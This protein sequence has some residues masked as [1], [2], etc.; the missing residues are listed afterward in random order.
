MPEISPSDLALLGTVANALK[1]GLPPH[2]DADDLIQAGYF[3]LADAKRRFDPQRGIKFQTYATPRIRGAMLDAIREADWAPRLVR[4]RREKVPKIH[5]I[6]RSMRLNGLGAEGLNGREKLYDFPD[7]RPPEEPSVEDRDQFE[8]SL[9]FLHGQMRQ[10]ILLNFREDKNL[11][12]IGDI[13]GLSESR[14]SQIRGQAFRILRANMNAP[15]NRKAAPRSNRRYG[16]IMLTCEELPGRTFT[17]KEAAA[18][19]GISNTAIHYAINHGSRA[20]QKR[21][22]FN[23]LEPS[24]A[25]PA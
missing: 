14:I 2:I 1:R 12:E 18:E 13:L 3:G 8:R 24:E 4:R 9:A 16:R 21:L 6:N 11:R 22:K 20:G 7:L 5:S 25:I 15:R 19:A 10:V 17:M 23:R